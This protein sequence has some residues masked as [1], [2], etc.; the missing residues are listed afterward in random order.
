M[1][2]IFVSWYSA[3][4]TVALSHDIGGMVLKKK[5]IIT[6]GSLLS[7]WILEDENSRNINVLVNQSLYNAIL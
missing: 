1:L 3:G 5:L 7:V 6:V 2:L 4:L